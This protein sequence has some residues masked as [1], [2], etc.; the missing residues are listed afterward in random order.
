MFT[1]QISQQEL[2]SD[3]CPIAITL[4]VPKAGDMESILSET[5]RLLVERIEAIEQ[6]LRELRQPI[7]DIDE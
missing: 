5:Q 3:H 6:E 2:L 7:R 1:E 4:D